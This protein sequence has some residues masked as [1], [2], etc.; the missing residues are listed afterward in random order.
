MHKEVGPRHS[1][2]VKRTK[3]GLRILRRTVTLVV[4]RRR[5]QGS[6]LYLTSTPVVSAAA[7]QDVLVHQ[8]WQPY[9]QIGPRS[10]VV[11]A[12]PLVL[13][14]ALPEWPQRCIKATA[15]G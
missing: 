6:Y 12:T 9:T 14:T 11:G 2:H 5:P 13:R 1:F 10:V 7:L 4:D 3:A 8:L 15:L